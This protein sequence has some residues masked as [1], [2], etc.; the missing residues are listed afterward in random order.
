MPRLSTFVF[1]F[2]TV[3]VL[4][5]T[6]PLELADSQEPSTQEPVASG[7]ED[8]F[9]RSERESILTIGGSIEMPPDLCEVDAR[10]EL[11]RAYN[12][13]VTGDYV[14]GYS[15]AEGKVAAG[16]N[17]DIWHYSVAL[18]NPN[19]NALV[20]GGDVTLADVA[21]QG[22]V[23]AGG[24]VSLDNSGLYP[25]DGSSGRTVR[26]TI[27]DFEEEARN[28]VTAS[29]LLGGLEPSGTVAVWGSEIALN[30]DDP[31][32][33][34]F[35]VA[36]SAVSGATYFQINVPEGSDVVVNLSGSNLEFSNFGI[37]PTNIETG[38]VLFNAPDATSVRIEAFA[39]S[40]S[41][42]APLASVDFD[43][44]QF[45]GTL[46]ARELAG[47][48]MEDSQSDGQFNHR[49]FTSIYCP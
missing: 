5:C 20:A 21:I 33:N 14:S 36:G 23:V 1:C 15:D 27:L 17:V 44:G 45:N 2:C 16:G 13:F 22:N 43:N 48:G 29:E 47:D 30:G 12:V 19:G 9:T 6:E 3:S 25:T 31:K 32:L 40:G 42:L 26:G 11:P 10:L 38:R 39:F 18:E 4:A 8:G 24:E 37:F 28:L 46:V 41:L 35:L 34:V 49:P 7:K